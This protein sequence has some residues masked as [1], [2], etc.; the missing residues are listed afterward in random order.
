MEFVGYSVTEARDA[1]GKRKVQKRENKFVF[2]IKPEAKMNFDEL[3]KWYLSLEKVKKL[4]TYDII[5]ITLNKFNKVFGKM[6]VGQVKPVDLEN[7]QAKRLRGRIAPATV[8]HEIGKTKSMIYKAFDN[9][10]VGGK[11]LKTF[12]KIKKTLVKGSDVRHR[13]LSPDEF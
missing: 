11:T 12:K 9:D 4:A 5:K 3:T 13:I 1:D 7:Y 6:V 10:M 2:D 8:D